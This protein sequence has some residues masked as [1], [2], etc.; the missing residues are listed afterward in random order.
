MLSRSHQ[1][2]TPDQSNILS[3][4]AD[5]WSAAELSYILFDRPDWAL[6]AS[7]FLCL[8]KPLEGQISVEEL[9]SEASSCGDTCH[10]QSRTEREPDVRTY[11]R[12]CVGVR[13]CVRLCVCVF[14]SVSG[15]EC[16]LRAFARLSR[17][18]WRA[19]LVACW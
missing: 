9:S 16:T 5:S 10:A 4:F 8:V 17:L 18:W 2:F 12:A 15:C 6:L 14:A 13:R 11:V 7:M 3:H 19:Q 1:A